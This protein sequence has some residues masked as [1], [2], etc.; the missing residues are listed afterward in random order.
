M[1]VLQARYL[2]RD[3][4]GR[5]IEDASGMLDRVATAIAEPCRSFGEDEELWY[6]RFRDRL[7][8]LEFLPCRKCPV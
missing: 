7:D 8:R 6:E 2:R 5:Q 4:T 1:A 3:E